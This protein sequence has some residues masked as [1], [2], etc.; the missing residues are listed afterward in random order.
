MKKILTFFLLIVLCLTATIS[1]A[2]MPKGYKSIYTV[3]GEAEKAPDVIGAKAA[4]QLIGPAAGWGN[5]ADWDFSEY[6]KLV[7]NLTFDPADAGNMFAVRFNVN[8]TATESNVKLLKFTLPTSGTNFSI[9]I[10]IEEYAQEGLFKVG[11]LII[12]NG[13]SHHS[14]NYDDGTATSMPLTVNY[15]AVAPKVDPTKMPDDYV[16]IYDVKGEAEK[17]PVCDWSKSCSS[18]YW[19]SRRLGQYGRLGLFRIFQ[20]CYQLNLRPCRC[21]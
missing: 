2:Q 14:F 9:E 21:R 19:T 12:Y 13:A 11:G 16:S 20:T 1:M 4:L 10:N 6:S 15:A 18:T 5:M 8:A 17:A 7:I 3:K